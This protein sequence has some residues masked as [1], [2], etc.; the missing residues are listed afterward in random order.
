MI[1]FTKYGFPYQEHLIHTFVGGSQLHGAKLDGT[2]DTD[3]YGVFIPPPEK[4][5]GL[6]PF[7]HFVHTTGDGTGNTKDDVDVTLYSL[8]KF[9]KLAAKGNP[10]VLQFLFTKVDLDRIHPCWLAISDNR[11][12]F[13]AKSHLS[14][15]LGY[16]NAQLQRLM[17]QRGQKNVNRTFL[18]A[19]YGYD[20][21]YAMHIVRL[22]GEATELMRYGT[23]TFPR[24]DAGVLIDIRR[25]KYKLSELLDIANE[26]EEQ[27]IAA[28]KESSLPAHV[29]RKALSELLADVYTEEWG[30]NKGS[31]ES[32]K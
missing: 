8:G 6:D 22:L 29:D 10:S 31:Y 9:A 24:P 17:G 21:K 1:D 26:F 3:Y 7:E 14:S 25:G 18:E 4:M 11:D 15:F 19:Q 27:A 12:L 30:Y 20:T 32:I 2:D 16:A 28:E 13:L 5:L 23:I